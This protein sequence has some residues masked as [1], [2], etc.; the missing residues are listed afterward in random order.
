LQG[1]AD[2]DEVSAITPKPTERRIQLGA[3]PAC[4]RRPDR[5]CF[6]ALWHRASTPAKAAKLNQTTVERTLAEHSPPRCGARSR[7]SGVG[8]NTT[9]AGRG[10]IRRLPPRIRPTSDE[11]KGMHR[12]LDESPSLGGLHSDATL[13]AREGI[14]RV[15]NH[16]PPVASTR[17]PK[18]ARAGGGAA[19]P[20]QR[21]AFNPS[22]P[23][24][25]SRRPRFTGCRA[26]GARSQDTGGG[27]RQDEAH[28][29][30][31][32]YQPYW[33][34]NG[35]GTVRTAGVGPLERLS[36]GDMG[37]IE[38]FPAQ[39]SALDY[40][41]F[42]HMAR[43]TGTRC[44]RIV[45]P[46]SVK[47]V[48]MPTRPG[49]PDHS[50]VDAHIGSRLRLRRTLLGMSQEKLAT[51]VGITFQQIQKYERGS[52][53]ISGSR[54]YDL[55]TALGV[56][57][58]FFFDGLPSRP[59]MPAPSLPFPDDALEP[60]TMRRE[61]ME[62]VRAYY[63]VPVAARQSVYHLLKSLARSSAAAA[64]TNGTNGYCVYFLNAEQG[65]EAA[66][67]VA[68]DDDA[69]ALW[70]AEGL[71]QACSDVCASFELWHGARNVGS[72]NDG[73]P[74][75]NKG[76]AAIARRQ[77][78]LVRHEEMLRDSSLRIAK[79]RQLLDELERAT[80]DSRTE[81]LAADA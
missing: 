25:F 7:R 74:P 58:A 64:G 72:V 16:D 24:G 59:A 53:R 38:R 15:M 23:A 48:P 36:A 10:H 45:L 69:T 78:L 75:D 19:E 32:C 18:M 44:P 41:L 68:A 40:P 29:D 33:C 60:S 54:L 55:A 46:S 51:L 21:F 3:L 28:D 8:P 37:K 57:V 73:A 56:P 35:A 39:S 13:L 50:I 76:G 14:S 11:V 12:R 71:F 47:S 67:A 49:L 62:V 26:K 27:Y 30:D 22:E 79:S 1:E 81:A 5:P 61:A 42:A 4:R 20:H 70:I 80:R 66:H 17:A 65:I 52:N 34:A 2:A 77:T 63:A 6:L 31:G 9:E 43:L